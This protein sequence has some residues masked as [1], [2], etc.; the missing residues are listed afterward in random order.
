MAK[1][2]LT[3]KFVGHSTETIWQSRI[4]GSLKNVP[5]QLQNSQTNVT[6]M[7]S[8]PILYCLA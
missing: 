1:V 3:L 4:K 5:S 7:S 6:L 2:V 8:N